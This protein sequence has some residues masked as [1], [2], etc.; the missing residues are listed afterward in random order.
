MINITNED[1]NRLQEKSFNEGY[2]CGFNVAYEIG[3]GKGKGIIL[4]KVTESIN[5]II[6]NFEEGSKI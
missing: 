3:M 6:K 1:L 5:D 4:E 2:E